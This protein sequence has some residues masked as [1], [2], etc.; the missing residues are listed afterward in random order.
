MRPQDIIKKKRDGGTLTREEIQFLITGYTEV[1]HEAAVS[2][3][4]IWW[5]ARRRPPPQ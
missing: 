4:R 3:R 5:T 2:R 1:N